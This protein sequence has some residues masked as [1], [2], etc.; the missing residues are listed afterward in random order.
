[1]KLT[2]NHSF[3][4]TNSATIQNSKYYFAAKLI[5]ISNVQI[6]NI[7]SFYDYGD[8]STRTQTPRNHANPAKVSEIATLDLTLYVDFFHGFLP[9]FSFVSFLHPPYFS[10]PIIGCFQGFH[11]KITIARLLKFQSKISHPN[12]NYNNNNKQNEHSYGRSQTK[13]SI[14]PFRVL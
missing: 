14:K 2:I 10:V 13:G 1:M 3:N 4:I 5:T 8:C 9:R 7:N 11:E 6:E 12:P